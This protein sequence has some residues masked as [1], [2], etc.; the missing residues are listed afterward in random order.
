MTRHVPYD[1]ECPG[2]GACFIPFEAGLPCPRCGRAAAEAF[3]FMPQ[4]VASLRFNLDAAGS[5][6]PR[7]WYVGSLGDHVLKLLFI[8]FEGFRGRD[9]AAREEPFDAYL[10]R[11]LGAMRW[12]DQDYLR[13]HVRDIARRV[14]AMME[15]ER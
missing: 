5:F 8:V 3:D 1:H 15:E 7:A 10:D 12:G 2:C 6:L 13:T 4:A 9:A 11:A 14:R